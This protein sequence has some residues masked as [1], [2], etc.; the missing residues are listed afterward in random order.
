MRNF[1]NLFESS[2]TAN[3]TG[4]GQSIKNLIKAKQN[5][6]VGEHLR[7]FIDEILDT[8]GGLLKLA[9]APGLQESSSD[10]I[11]NL[12][13]VYNL[14]A[15][16][17]DNF[18]AQLIAHAE[19]AGIDAERLIKL[20]TDCRTLE[21]TIERRDAPS[22]QKAAT[23]TVKGIQL[24][25]RGEIG[26][27]DA[28]IEQQAKE[29]AEEFGLKEIWARNL[30]GMFGINISHQDRLKF[31][32]ACR[33]PSPEKR[34]LNIK[35][36][37]GKD[38]KGSQGKLEDVV[39]TRIPKIAEVFKEVKN[40]LL[41]ISLSTGQ[42][43]ATGPFE[44]VLA[45]MGGAKKPEAKEGGD[46]VFE[47]DGHRYKIEVKGGSIGAAAKLTAKGEFSNSAKLS[48]A[49]LDSTA[50]PDPTKKGGELGGSVLR[51]VGNEWLS[52]NLP[53]MDAKLKA[54]WNASDFR[55]GTA[56]KPTLQNLKQCLTMINKLKP[57]GARSLV[58]DM[59]SR[60]FPTATNAPGFDFKNSITK[61][62]KA[63][64]SIDAAAIAKEQ[65]T[66]ALIQYVLGKGND[67]FI[68]FNSSLQE[69]KMIMGMEGILGV[70]NSTANDVESSMVRFTSTMTMGNSAK[71]SPGVY[72]GPDNK[73]N[74]AKRYV[75]EYNQSPERVKLRQQAL[76]AGDQEHPDAD[77]A[78]DN[79]T[80]NE[81]HIPIVSETRH[82]TISPLRA[83]RT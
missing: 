29:F 53:G 70:Y 22:F 20:I 33:D 80:I 78:W 64:E 31:L 58:T 35:S 8:T 43:G 25:T 7:A 73:S 10:T 2:Q 4:F 41:D 1:I 75:E 19:E 18:S 3:T 37:M 6:K 62:L 38:G 81:S 55:P 14:A 13:F 57:N 40:T 36:L 83:R 60:M 11:S 26:R 59:M 66:M 77:S 44:A 71:C 82:I 47:V 15:T 48:E 42:R 5:P 32:A 51:T 49:W 9:V 72:F 45:I 12:D 50:N 65:G 27:L 69:Y 74:A 39:N 16:E 67:G 23:A 63:I 24:N 28:D 56:Q 61:I 76:S 46:V 30:I 54:L 68:F 79:K 34:A 52:A 21:A 17:I